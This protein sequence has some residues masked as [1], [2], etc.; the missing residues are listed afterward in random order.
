M[1]NTL[2]GQEKANIQIINSDFTYFDQKLF[3]D[4]RRL[5]GNVKF[6]HKGAI[7]SCD[8]AWYYI[9]DNRFK[10]FNNVKI[11]Q[12]DSI[13]L[14]GERLNYDGKTKQA[15]VYDDISLKD[16]N[17]LL[18]TDQLNYSLET[19][20]ASYYYGANIVNGD[21]TLTSKKGKYLSDTKFL[22]FK[23]SVVLNN[24]SYIIECDTLHFHSTKEIAYFYGPTTIKSDENLIYCENGWYNTITDISQYN[25]NAFLNN[26]QQ[27]LSGDSMFYDRNNGYGI[28]INNVEILDTINKYT[29]YGHKAEYFERSDSS[30]ITEN[31][32][33]ISELDDDSLFLHS[34]TIV[35][36]LDSLK[37]RQIIAYTGVKFFSQN[38]QGKCQEL[39]Y[40]MRD[41]TI[42]MFN[43]PV[44]WSTDYQ[45][46]AQ[47]MVLFLK[48]ERLDRLEMQKDA[49]I[50]SKDSMDLYNQIKGKHTIGFFKDNDLHK[51]FVDGN[52]QATYVIKDEFEKVSGINTVSCSQMNIYIEDK[53]IDRISFQHQ[54]NA[55]I[56]PFEELPLKWKR[57][58]GFI[59]RF[60]ERILDKNGI[61]N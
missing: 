33:L 1:V 60:S 15:I 61:W 6:E 2:Y 11:N 34:D 13:F 4:I 26:G 47:H 32:L 46:T 51:L 29:I 59:N 37:Y 20:I 44:L 30:I 22:I 48:D 16:K 53:E 24:P 52:G 36:N 25:K 35:A 54:P 19:N 28:A 3:P 9:Y 10:A 5:V 21:N 14:N 7:M 23:D 42:H 40:F 43:S 12:G 45:L 50:T 27:T 39:F 8:S 58:D 57:L 18:T 17:M 55:I 49:F 38:L 41:S 56:Y 31:P